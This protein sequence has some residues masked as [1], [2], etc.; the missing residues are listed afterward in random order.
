[1][2]HTINTTTNHY[3]Q[4]LFTD[5]LDVLSL[6]LLPGISI[7]Q[8]WR[9]TLDHCP[10]VLFNGPCSLFYA[11]FD[12]TEVRMHIVSV[13][14]QACQCQ[15]CEIAQHLLLICYVDL[16]DCAVVVHACTD[17]PKHRQRRHR[18]ELLHSYTLKVHINCLQ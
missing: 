7:G 4:L 2:L 6:S 10:T 11:S 16:S 8:V 12:N 13:Q 14:L 3:K 9:V 18:G 17:L 15:C 1:V 5:A